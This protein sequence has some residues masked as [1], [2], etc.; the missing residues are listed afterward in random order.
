MDLKGLSRIADSVSSWEE[1]IEGVIQ[2]VN[3]AIEVFSTSR[4][5]RVDGKLC[6]YIIIY[7][8]QNPVE[9]LDSDVHEIWERLEKIQRNGTPILGKEYLGGREV[10]TD[11]YYQ[12]IWNEIVEPSDEEEFTDLYSSQS[13]PDISDSLKKLDDSDSK[14]TDEETK[15]IKWLRDKGVSSESIIEGLDSWLDSDTLKDLLNDLF[16]D[17]DIPEEGTFDIKSISDLVHDACNNDYDSVLT[18]VSSWMSTDQ[19]EEFASDFVRL[20]DI[21]DSASEETLVSKWNNLYKDKI[22]A[23]EEVDSFLVELSNYLQEVS[24]DVAYVTVDDS[25]EL[26]K[27]SHTEQATDTGLNFKNKIT[28]EDFKK[29][30]S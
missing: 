11:E 21:E 19:E 7:K 8:K 23:D 18:M 4:G 6:N 20:Y 28:A 9:D 22:P 14:I 1:A 27:V 3:P 24:D 5:S 29:L 26:F 13:F 2:S 17:L 12:F 30:L 25:G 10:E 16:I 15:D